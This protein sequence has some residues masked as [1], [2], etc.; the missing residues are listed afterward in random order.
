M[1]PANTMPQSLL[2]LGRIQSLTSSRGM[3][4]RV[5]LPLSCELCLSVE[6]ALGTT[7]TEGTWAL[8]R[9]QRLF[10]SKQHLKVPT[11]TCKQGTVTAGEQNA[12]MAQWR[13]W[14]PS[15]SFET[16]EN[17]AN[18]HSVSQQWCSE[19]QNLHPG[20]LTWNIPITH[21]ER[22]MIFQTL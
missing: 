10:S 9:R 4:F 11:A 13:Q 6:A 3:N 19:S 20:R 17:Q 8:S 18:I 12:S 15:H 2:K 7:E 22:K 16:E 1:T 21:L 14:L 5:Q